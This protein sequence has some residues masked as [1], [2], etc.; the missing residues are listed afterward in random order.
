[1]S[2]KYSKKILIVDDEEDILI[3]LGNILKRANFE[4]ISARSGDEAIKSAKEKR[5]DLIIMDVLMPGIDGG[6][7]AGVLAEDPDTA[8]IP[9]VFL[10]GILTKEEELAVKEE[11]G[12]KAGKRFVMAK[13]V[14]KEELLEMINKIFPG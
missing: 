6:G 5:P 10:T 8:G 1:M 9:V 2:A 12:R 7:A 13:P 14:S 3:S 4:V 11:G